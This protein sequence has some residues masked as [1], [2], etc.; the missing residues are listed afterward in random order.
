MIQEASKVTMIAR[1]D[2]YRLVRQAERQGVVVSELL[3]PSRSSFFGR[4]VFAGV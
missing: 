3:A 2:M 4:Q 1:V